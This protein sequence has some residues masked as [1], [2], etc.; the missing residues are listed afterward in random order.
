[1]ETQT[2]I[3]LP[4][5]LAALET[6]LTTTRR[7]QEAQSAPPARRYVAPLV[8]APVPDISAEYRL[9]RSAM[10]RFHREMTKAAMKAVRYR[11][12][13]LCHPLADLREQQSMLH[14]G[15]MRYR[16]FFFRVLDSFDQNNLREGPAMLD[17]AERMAKLGTEVCEEVAAAI[18][19][20]PH[21]PKELD[22][23]LF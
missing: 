7:M 23:Q 9:L 5:E 2:T 18:A 1:M 3:K 8:E 21:E 11:V 6:Q 15:G 13:A 19:A 4:E 17:L 12:G 10:E 20:C 14:Q 16:T 22:F